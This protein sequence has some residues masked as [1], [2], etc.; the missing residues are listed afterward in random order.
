MTTLKVFT[1][2]ASPADC[3]SNP[4]TAEPLKRQQREESKDKSIVSSL[5]HL[6]SSKTTTYQTGSQ[7]P[8]GTGIPVLKRGNKWTNSELRGQMVS[9][10]RQCAWS[11]DSREGQSRASGEGPPRLVFDKREIA[12]FQ[13]VGL[14]QGT[15]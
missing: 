13:V 10:G 7:S 9:K 1:A 8:S 14:K 12:S 15:M 3:G 5:C 2:A 4:D 6:K 11:R